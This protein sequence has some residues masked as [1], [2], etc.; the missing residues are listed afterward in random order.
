[1]S[2]RRHLQHF[3]LTSFDGCSWADDSYF[4]PTSLP[5]QSHLIIMVQPQQGQ[6][7]QGR[8]RQ[9]PPTQTTPRNSRNS[10][11]SRIRRFRRSSNSS[12]CNCN[13]PLLLIVGTGALWGCG[14]LYFRATLLY[15]EQQ[16]ASLTK[17]NNNIHNDPWYG[18]QPAL[19]QHDNDANND[20]KACPSVRACLPGKKR[21][22]SR[23][24]ARSKC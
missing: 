18:W 17:Q 5:S 9:P 8:L 4:V 14:L 6:R 23:P 15:Q 10:S 13:L 12:C 7:D 16:A 3:L 2:G 1:M 20:S 19:P 11:S 22:S 21:Q 24:L